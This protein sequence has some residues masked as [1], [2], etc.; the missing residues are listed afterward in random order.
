MLAPNTAQIERPRRN[1][2]PIQRFEPGA[3]GRPTLSIQ[4]EIPEEPTKPPLSLN[5]RATTWEARQPS[6]TR[7]GASGGA[8][9]GVYEERE[10]GTRAPRYPHLHP[11][12][13]EIS[14]FRC[15]LGCCGPA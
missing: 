13:M 12:Q 5:P 7:G 6:Y 10:A 2:V 1:A 8:S 9:G 14:Q 15:R 4:G 3:S 11:A